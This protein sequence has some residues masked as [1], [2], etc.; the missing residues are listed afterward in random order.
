[1]AAPPSIIAGS[2]TRSKSRRPPWWKLSGVGTQTEYQR[3]SIGKLNNRGDCTDVPIA[4]KNVYTEGFGW[5]NARGLL[6]REWVIIRYEDTPTA[7][8]SRRRRGDIGG[9]IGKRW[10]G[11]LGGGVEWGTSAG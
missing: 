5:Y 8:P 6:G 3:G 11:T 10:T 2:I 9:T 1:M 4:V 7:E